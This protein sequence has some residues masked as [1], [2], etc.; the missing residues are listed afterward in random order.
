MDVSQHGEEQS[1]PHILLMQHE[2]LANH[3]LQGAYTQVVLAQV[4]IAKDQACHDVARQ[5]LL[6][7]IGHV[8]QRPC[9]ILFQ[10]PPARLQKEELG[11]HAAT[12]EPKQGMGVLPHIPALLRKGLQCITSSHMTMPMEL[13]ELHQVVQFQQRSGVEALLLKQAHA[14]EMTLG[15]YREGQSG[16]PIQLCRCW[17][18][19]IVTLRRWW[20]EGSLRVDGCDRHLRCSY[21]SK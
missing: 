3:L 5:E 1:K 16:I 12:L 20:T 18:R 11:A 7:E 9:C 4:D 19:H 17:R 15:Y 14:V 2:G 10:L 8:L 6:V 21:V 13:Q